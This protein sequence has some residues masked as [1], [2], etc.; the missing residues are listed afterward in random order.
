MSDTRII[1]FFNRSTA[2]AICKAYTYLDKQPYIVSG[3]RRG[4]IECVAVSPFDDLNKMH[5]LNE[6]KSCKDPVKAL[7]FYTPTF[8]DV[9]LILQID[10]EGDLSYED[11]RTY[12]GKRGES[13]APDLLSGGK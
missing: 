12:L 1:P 7:Q 10:G 8:F 4:I 9:I 3:I 5:F 2:E 6:Y 13:L 11:I